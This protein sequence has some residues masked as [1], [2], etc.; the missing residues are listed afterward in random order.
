VVQAAVLDSLLFD[1][2]PF[3]QD[4]FTTPG[5]NFRR[6]EVADFTALAER[7]EELADPHLLKSASGKLFA[8]IDDREVMSP[9]VEL[10]ALSMLDR[11]MIRI[12]VEDAAEL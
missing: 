12:A 11:H 9:P 10:E 2:P 4:G 7:V 6:G 1:A 3:S 8:E 5:V